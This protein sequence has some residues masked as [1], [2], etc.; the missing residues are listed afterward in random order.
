MVKKTKKFEP[1]VIADEQ[2]E[3]EGA[4]KP[5]TFSNFEE[6]MKR[7]EVLQDVAN[8][9][10]EILRDNDLVQTKKTEAPYFDDDEVYKK[11]EAEEA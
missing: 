6:L 2:V 1:R 11:L 7:V 3:Y 10:A 4:D 9:H 8:E 5:E